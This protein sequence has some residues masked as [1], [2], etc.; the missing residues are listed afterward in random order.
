MGD[1]ID[2]GSHAHESFAPFLNLGE[3][4]IDAFSEQS[5]QSRSLFRATHGGISPAEPLDGCGNMVGGPEHPVDVKAESPR[6]PGAG[7]DEGDKRRKDLPQGIEH[8]RG[9][10]G[11]HG[12]QGTAAKEN[13]L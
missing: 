12:H 1:Y 9:N 11:D 3:E 6:D 13:Q 5:E 8:Q 4:E 7:E 2:V 10:G